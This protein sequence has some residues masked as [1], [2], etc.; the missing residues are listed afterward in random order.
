MLVA[1]WTFQKV[2]M[3]LG[4]ISRLFHTCLTVFR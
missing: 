1:E 3:K 4:E 2:S